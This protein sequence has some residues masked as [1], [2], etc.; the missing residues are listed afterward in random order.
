MQVIEKYLYR[1]RDLKRQVKENETQIEEL[2]AKKDSL[3]DSMLRAPRL[4]SVRVQGGA[5]VD[6]VYDAV[7]KMVDVY[8]HLINRQ[9]D[10]IKSLYWEMHEITAEVDNAQLSDIER[11]FIRLRYFED[12]GPEEVADKMGYCERHIWR[13]SK[14]A[15]KVMA[16]TIKD[17]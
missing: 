11:Q 13:I 3:A 7:Q 16:L 5:S 12:L 9:T 14:N 1:Y 17:L 4:D 15:L 8:G 6:P 2:I 10:C